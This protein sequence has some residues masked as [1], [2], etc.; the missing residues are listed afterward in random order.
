MD[1]PDALLLFLILVAVLGWTLAL[2]ALRRG[3]SAAKSKR[4]QSAKY[5]ALTEQF[6]P[7]MKQW[8]FD[9]EGFRFLGKPIDG[10]QFTNDAIFLVEIKAAGSQL[11]AEQKIVRDLV[12]AGRVGWMRFNVAE[13][14]ST[15]I[16][17]PW[18]K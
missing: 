10:V 15:E 2:A 8:P 1:V 9:P 17:K 18:E 13:S 16:L 6:A 11:S 3:R 7:W 14:R 5:G 12:A 4:S